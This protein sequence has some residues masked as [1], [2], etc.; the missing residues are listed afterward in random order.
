M[1]SPATNTVAADQSGSRRGRLLTMPFAL[2]TLTALA[3]FTALGTLLPTFPK[4][5]EDDL[6]G[7][8]LVVGVAVGIF[9]ISAAILRPW[10]GRFGDRRGRRLLVVGGAL[11]VALSVAGYALVDNV[12]ILIAMR[13]VTGAGEAA[14]F[15]GLA[16]AVQDLAPSDRRGE[17]ASYF[18]VAVFAGLAI[19][20]TLGERIARNHGYHTTWVCAGALALLAAAF[21]SA[22]PVGEPSNYKPRTVLHPAALKPGLVLFLG[23]MPFTAFS[24]FVAL[25]AKNRLGVDNVAP[26]FAAHAGAALIIRLF[27]ARL[28]DRLGWRRASLVSLTAASIAGLVFGGWPSIIGVYVATGFLCIGQSFLFP[29][30]F[31]AVVH[32]APEAERS[33][34]VGTFSL[35]FDLASG[36]GAPFL[37]LVVSLSNY[38]GAFFA[39]ALIGASGFI[40]LRRL[41]RSFDAR[42]SVAGA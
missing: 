39:S 3:Y 38:R 4:Y 33:H 32:D 23:L 6:G 22:T 13:I 7:S 15:V 14:A 31:T 36:I 11:L 26:V 30:L 42:P 21:G 17:A 5:I 20:P 41:R 35:F 29:A 12:A 28:P 27:G 2:I 19:G 24:A 34:A 8:G 16:T 40:A 37:G 18:S 9:S 25:Y 1:D 10:A